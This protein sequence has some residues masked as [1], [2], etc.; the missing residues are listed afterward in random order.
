MNTITFI[1]QTRKLRQG[2]EVVGGGL[3]LTQLNVNV[4]SLTSKCIHMFPIWAKRIVSFQLTIYKGIAAREGRCLDG[5]ML[6]TQEMPCGKPGRCSYQM[7]QTPV[8]SSLCGWIW[9]HV[10]RRPSYLH[11]G[12][13]FFFSSSHLLSLP[14]PIQLAGW[15]WGRGSHDSSFSTTWRMLSLD[16]SNKT[17]VWEEP[18]T[19]CPG[20]YNY[21]I[22]HL[23]LN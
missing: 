15:G 22:K 9:D 20:D 23:Y 10:P 3:R 4:F 21:S 1:S 8:V 2:Q 5:V 6:V 7:R 19:N 16:R 17:E 12:R 13:P 14:W 18:L 11:T